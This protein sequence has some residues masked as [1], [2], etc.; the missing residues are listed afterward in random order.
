MQ[1]NIELPADILILILEQAIGDRQTLSNLS[2]ASRAWHDLCLPYLLHTV[3][4]SSHDIGHQLQLQND[5]DVFVPY[6]DAYVSNTYRP[7]DNLVARQRA[8]LRLMTASPGLARHVKDFAWTLI[9]TDFDEDALTDDDRYTWSVFGSLTNVSRLD[10]GSIHGIVDD[11]YVRENPAELFPAVMD[12]RLV[13]WMH[14]GLVRAIVGALDTSSL[15]TLDLDHLCDEGAGIGGQPISIDSADYALGLAQVSLGR[16]G[17]LDDEVIQRQEAGELPIV[18][19]PMWLPLRLLRVLA[20]SK[21]TTFSVRLSAFDH[22]MV[23]EI[24]RS[25][26]AELALFIVRYA[27][28]I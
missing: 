27:S 25:M 8:F 11:A 7:R 1:C 3:D 4:L 2:R 24:Y 9:W 26:F 5:S 14:R 18:P 12:L 16:E 22:T 10:L 23:Q 17:V 21:L 15:R 6:H 20:L 28:T 19:G 13:G